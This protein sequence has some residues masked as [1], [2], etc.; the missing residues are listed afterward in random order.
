MWKCFI[1]KSRAK[2]RKWFQIQLRI[3]RTDVLDFRCQSA[4]ELLLWWVTL[5]LQRFPSARQEK[6]SSEMIPVTQ[7]FAQDPYDKLGGLN[8]SPHFMEEV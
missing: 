2:T 3:N 8:H 1:I 5:W 6:P 4:T 7:I